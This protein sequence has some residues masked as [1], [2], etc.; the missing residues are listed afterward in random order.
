MLSALLIYQFPQHYALDLVRAYSSGFADRVLPGFHD[1]EAE[2]DAA[3]EAYFDSRMNQ[4]ASYDGPWED[5]GAVA[6]DAEEH[7]FSLYT[8]LEFVRQQVT[9]LAIAGLYHLWERLLK[10]FLETSFRAIDPPVA[11]QTV[12]RA[13]FNVMVV[14]LRERFGWDI[15]AEDFF[16]DLDQLHLVANVVKHGDGKS[17][18]AL[19]EKA[20]R[21]FHDFGHPSA[22]ERRGADDLRLEREHFVQFAG[23]VAI[24]RCE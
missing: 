2:A 6:E 4:V 17:C 8:D 7:G 3:S 14:W 1:I 23:S 10:E 18:E 5:E 24:P 19:L 15:E 16:A 22:N 20:P 21:L 12:R 11:P 9:G 13:D